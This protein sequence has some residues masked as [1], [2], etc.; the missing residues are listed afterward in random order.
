MLRLAIAQ[1]R[2]RK[3][4]YAENLLPLG[5]VFRD[6][7][8]G[9]RSARAHHRAGNRA[10]RLL[11]RRRC[12]RAGSPRERLFDDLRRQHADSGPPPLDV[13]LG[14]YEVHRQP[15]LQLRPCTPR[16]ADRDAG[17]RHVHRKIFLPT[18]GVFDEE[19]FVE[20]GRTCR[21]S[22]PAGAV[23]PS[24]I[25]EDAWH[26]FTPMLAALDGAQLIIVPSASPARGVV[27]DRRHRRPADQP[28]PLGTDHPGHRRRARRLRGPRA[29]GGLRGRQGLS[30]RLDRVRIP[31]GDIIASGPIFEEAV[32]RGHARFRRDHPGP[33][34][35]AR[36]WP[37]WRCGLPHLLGLAACGTSVG[38]WRMADAGPKQRA[39]AATAAGRSGGDAAA[40][41]HVAG[42][43]ARDRCRSTRRWLVEFLRDELRRRRGFAKVVI[44]LSGGVDSSLVAFLAAEAL[45]PAMS[46][47]CGCR[48]APPARRA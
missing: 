34:R 22:T 37:I 8:A 43:S 6:A 16:S 46:S 12:A 20:P 14:F 23:P 9:T 18:Y 25:C 30:R 11:P 17:I 42:D 33:R 31:R 39:A 36:C 3:G 45:G 48:T 41:A 15:A 32:I 35:S 1:M 21:R 2:P 7:A 19:R 26:S 10:H 27:H 13:A 29:A 40:I 24:L 47:V 5:D 4:A 28:R 38:W 44:G